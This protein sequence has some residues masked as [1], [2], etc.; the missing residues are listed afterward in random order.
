MPASRPELEKALEAS[1]LMEMQAM[2]LYTI[3][4][5]LS[6]NMDAQRILRFLAEMEESHVARL[7]E[8]FPGGRKD[9]AEAMARVD[10]VKAFR[11]DAWAQHKARLAGAG[12]T[13]ASPA[14]DYLVFAATGEA[15]AQKHY[16]RLSADAEEP[17]LK[18]LFR[19]LAL[20]EAN[21][22]EQ[23]RRV[24]RLLSGERGPR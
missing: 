14:D 2:H 4:A 8:L 11:E 24:R 12:I 5:G 1:I 6:V 9:P 7:V 17:A 21:H 13:D 10:M 19:T 23:I 20:E 16:E 15:H 22:G 18:E 3:L